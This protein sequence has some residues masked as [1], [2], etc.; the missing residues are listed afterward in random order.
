MARPGLFLGLGGTGRWVLTYVKK[1]LLETNQGQLPP[2]VHLVAYDTIGSAAAEQDVKVGNVTLDARDGEFIFLG[3]NIERLVK[4]TADGRHPHLQSWLQANHYI[5]SLPAAAY[6]LSEGAGQMRP[7]GRMGVFQDLIARHNSKIWGSLSSAITGLRS[8]VDPRRPL[9]ISVIAS[10]AGGTG[11]GMFIDI[12]HIARVIAESEVGENFSVRAFLLLPRAFNVIPGGDGPNMRARAFAAMRELSRFMTVF[13]NRSYPMIYSPN[14]QS[15]S[16]PATKRIFDMC[17]L[18]DA[19]RDW[20]TLVNEDPT[21]GVYPSIADAIQAI[22][23]EECGGQLTQHIQ[24][25]H[26]IEQAERNRD[27]DARNVA[28]YSALG[29]YTLFLPVHEITQAG[30]YRFALEFLQQLV[31]PT[32]NAYGNVELSDEHNAEDTGSIIDAVI[33]FLNMSTSPNGIANTPFMQQIAHTISSGGVTNENL[34]REVSRR[35]QG[36]ITTFEPPDT[37]PELTPIKQRVRTML[38]TALTSRV[39]NSREA[40]DRPS[41]A[42]NR[43]ENG[44]RQ[45]R[46][47]YLGTQRADGRFH[48][49]EFRRALEQYGDIHYERFRALLQ[50]ETL[51]I[52]NGRTETDAIKSKGGK[53]GYLWSFLKVLATQIQDFLDFMARVDQERAHEQSITRKQQQV[54]QAQQQMRA[55]A[56]KKTFW[57]STSGRAFGAQEGYLAREQELIDLQK[58]ELLYTYVTEVAQRMRTY[59]IRVEQATEKWAAILA[60]GDPAVQEPGV[61]Q[62]LRARQAAIE[63]ERASANDLKVRKAETDPAYETAI[64][65]Q[66]TAGQIERLFESLSWSYV[67]RE[68]EVELGLS[69]TTPRDDRSSQTYTF[70]TQAAVDRT[71]ASELNHNLLLALSRPLFDRLKDEQTIAKRLSATY[72][73]RNLSDQLRQNASPLITFSRLVATGQRPANFLRVRFGRERGE[74]EYFDQVKGNIGAETGARDQQLQLV[75]SDDPYQ[76]SLIYTIDVLRQDSLQAYEDGKQA[77]IGS[78]KQELLHIFPAEVNAVR[79][80]QRLQPELRQPYRLLS[81]EVVFMLQYE[82]RVKLFVRALVYD[83]IGIRTTRDDRRYNLY[84]LDLPQL[85]VRDDL[86]IDTHVGGDEIWLTHPIGGEP[87]LMRAID[88]FVFLAQDIRTEEFHVPITYDDVSRALLQAEEQEGPPSMNMTKLRETLSNGEI[89]A[90]QRRRQ[91]VYR[92]LGAVMQLII[93]DEISRLRVQQYRR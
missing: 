4:E 37:S 52:L 53:L 13:G 56:A 50:E 5:G 20:N 65:N 66:Y 23:D 14:D 83:L 28:F 17:Y 43:I 25:I 64:Y 73:P 59:V 6:D 24:N 72:V 49:G 22:L 85:D 69:L 92:D 84:R 63:A 38:N 86:D 1:Y 19:Q 7:F 70:A 44:V 90:L 2:E 78:Q 31:A 34:I 62:V 67:D 36:W 61:Y 74:E 87:D 33:H 26:Q 79:Y 91:Q 16:Q 12:A 60:L 39:Q 51:A 89:Q 40:K 88:T 71:K 27:E 42:I 8:R 55:D 46:N 81:P 58:N 54:N 21:E 80:E 93:R 15:L 75:Q 3:G 32:H 11:A 82:D 68:S 9:S 30:A 47:D 77:Y 45:F 41:D 48:G 76:C 10:L 57:G 29:T 35:N 18:I